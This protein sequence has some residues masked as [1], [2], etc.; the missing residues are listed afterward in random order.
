MNHLYFQLFTIKGEKVK[1][2]ILKRRSEMVSHFIPF[3]SELTCIFIIKIAATN[4]QERIAPS[5]IITWRII[6]LIRALV[7]SFLYLKGFHLLDA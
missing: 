7:P 2:R 6:S 3:G 4:K 1:R 5:I